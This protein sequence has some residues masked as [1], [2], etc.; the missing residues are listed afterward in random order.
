[1][2]P[3]RLLLIPAAALLAA[4]AGN[5]TSDIAG[6]STPAGTTAGEASRTSG[7]YDAQPYC[8]L[9]RRLEAAGEDAFSGLGRD[10]TAAQYEAAERNFVLDNQDL[11][12][13]LVDAA[14][15]HLT[16]EIET[17]LS[18]M[19]QRGGLVEHRVS[20]S[21]AAAAEKGILSFERRH[22]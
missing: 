8:K 22:C 5:S 15:A 21:A 13:G 4:C 19:R 6:P 17:F 14:P 2:T 20:Q 1:M 18:A 16:D 9:T 7:Q 11:L 3:A 12:G 10:A